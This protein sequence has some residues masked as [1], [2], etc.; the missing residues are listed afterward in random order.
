M[1]HSQSSIQAQT[2]LLRHASEIDTL[3]KNSL[4][5]VAAGIIAPSRA[6]AEALTPHE[7]LRRAACTDITLN[8]QERPPAQPVVGHTP[9]FRKA[10][11]KTKFT[12]LVRCTFNYLGGNLKRSCASHRIYLPPLS[13]QLCKRQPFLHCTSHFDE[14]LEHFCVRQFDRINSSYENQL[15]LKIRQELNARSFIF[16]TKNLKAVKEICRSRGG[17]YCRAANQFKDHLSPCTP[18]FSRFSG[19][20]VGNV[21]R[22][23]YRADTSNSLYP[24][25]SILLGIKC[26]KQDKQSPPHS[27]YRQKC[28]DKPYEG[29]LHRRRHAESLHVS[30]L[31]AI[32]KSRACLF[33]CFPSMRVA[34]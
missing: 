27:S 21:K 20:R 14:R 31:P 29:D 4:C 7:M 22:H 17:V 15:L 1:T 23:C 2:A 26:A 18:C 8:A 33:P 6:A 5:C 16:R 19:L 3:V 28:P 13:Q 32:K 11:V 12:E 9:Y 10:S 24:S 30:W 34:A 25:C